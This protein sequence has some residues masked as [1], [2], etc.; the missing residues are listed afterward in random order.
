MSEDKAGSLRAALFNGNGVAKELIVAL[1]IFSSIITAVITAAELYA[2]YRRDLRQIDRSIDFIGKSYL[3][4]LT[5]AVWVADREQVQTQLDGLL[6]LPDIEYIG[7][8]VDGKTSW[9]GGETVS[10]RVVSADIPI[11]RQHRGQALTIGTVHVVASVDRVV[12]R[13]WRQLL[14]TLLTNA[15]KTLLVAGFMLLVFQYLVTRHLA[16]IATFVR[17]IDPA[18]PRGEQMQLDRPPG[19][20]WRPDILDTVAGSING[21]STS[22]AATTAELRRSEERLQLVL[23]GSTDAA[24]DLD[25]QTDE[26]YYS[27]PNPVFCSGAMV[28]PDLVLTAGHCIKGAPG[29]PCTSVSFVFG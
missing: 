2:E 29:D 6:R 10:Q 11:T 17:R 18:A 12:D 19:G 25:L 22:L 27:Q 14:L 1:L 24:W 15:V 28:G 21:L 4:A 9:S 23:R 3:P 8:A 26:P 5:E 7:I 16:R 13:L 20:R